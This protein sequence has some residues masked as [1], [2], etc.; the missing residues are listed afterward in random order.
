MYI[1]PKASLAR[2]REA[3]KARDNRAEIV[4][5][6]SHGQITRRDL[7]KWGFHGHWIAR[8]KNGLS[9]FAR[10]AF[11]AVPTGTPRSPLYGAQK[12]T[13]AC[14]GFHCKLRSHSRAMPRLEMRCFLPASANGQPSAYRIIPISPPARPMRSSG[15]HIW[16]R[17]DRRPTAR[18]NFR[19]SAVGRILSQ[20]RLR[21]VAWTDRSQQ[22]VS[23]QFSNS[24]A[25]QCLDFRSWPLREWK[26]A[27]TSDQGPLW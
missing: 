26:L 5:A 17:A 4:K 24:E 6:L 7:Y 2:Q 19:S 18:R 15:I 8:A 22:P 3:Q 23:S 9:P 16:E 10:S 11:A 20:S 13:T 25:E 21:A 14:R 1:S 12:F 27:S